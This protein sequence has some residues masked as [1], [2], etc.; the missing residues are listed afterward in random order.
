M[1]APAPTLAQFR[2]I[3]RSLMRAGRGFH[4]YHYRTYAQR[5]VRDAFRQAHPAQGEA[6]AAPEVLT[7]RYQECQNT[8]GLIQ[9]QAL[10]N[11]LY[12]TEPIVIEK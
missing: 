9:R 3:Y 2:S 12:S 4:A 11:R 7:A 10:I 8:L 5:R 1:T 6:A